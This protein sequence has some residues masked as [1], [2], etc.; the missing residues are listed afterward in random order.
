MSSGFP[1]LLPGGFPGRH[2]GVARPAGQLGPRG[3][4]GEAREAVGVGA[5]WRGGGAP[6][7]AGTAGLGC[8]RSRP[9]SRGHRP[10]R[11]PRSQLPGPPCTG[12]RFLSA[13]GSR[14]EPDAG[15]RHAAG[16]L[17]VWVVDLW[18]PLLA[19]GPEPCRPRFPSHLLPCVFHFLVWPAGLQALLQNRVTFIYF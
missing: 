1:H 3:Q 7:A 9:T 8:P 11:R 15:P 2:V 19:S 12:G 6:A 5:W 4:S 14:I 17:V 13:P 10:G 16:P 18:L